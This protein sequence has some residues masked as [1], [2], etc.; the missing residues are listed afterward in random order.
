MAFFFNPPN[1][2]NW[3]A[4]S[5]LLRLMGIVVLCKRGFL[6]VLCWAGL[7]ACCSA[8]FVRLF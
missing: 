5:A 2:K 3:F 1:I 8:F 4:R 7:A 6:L